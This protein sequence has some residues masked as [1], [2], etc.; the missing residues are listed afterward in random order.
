MSAPHRFDQF[1]P[2]RGNY[3]PPSGIYRDCP[4]PLSLPATATMKEMSV[5]AV[6][7]R[8]RLSPWLWATGTILLVAAAGLTTWHFRRGSSPAAPAAAADTASPARLTKGHDY[9]VHVKLIELADHLP[10]GKQWDRMDDS[11][12][13]IRFTLTWRQN[14]IWKSIEKSNT[15]IGSWDFLKVDLRQVI[16]GGQTDLEGMVNAPLVHHAGGESVELKVW[17]EDPVGSDDAGT[18]VIKLDDLGPGENTIA[19]TGGAAERVK[20][21]TVSLIDRRTPMPD[22]V[23]MISNR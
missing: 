1:L 8:S 9:Y 23:N 22:L 11:G 2:P 15:L 6:T 19:L 4:R 7:L 20:R 5:P 14:V 16:T 13:D 18:V 10:A 17:D 3:S 21:V 12:P